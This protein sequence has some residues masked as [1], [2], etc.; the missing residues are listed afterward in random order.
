MARWAILRDA[1]ATDL[2]GLVENDWKQ[3]ET[4]REQVLVVVPQA[5]MDSRY[6]PDNVRRPTDLSCAKRLSYDSA[7][8]TRAF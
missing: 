2:N 4:S 1:S 8:A 7:D 5:S 6:G 3:A